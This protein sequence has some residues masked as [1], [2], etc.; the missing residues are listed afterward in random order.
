[1]LMCLYTVSIISVRVCTR[2]RVYRVFIITA[3]AVTATRRVSG[4]YRCVLRARVRVFRIVLVGH[5]DPRGRH[6]HS[7][8]RR[9]GSS[10]R[11]TRTLD[12]TVT[13]NT[14]C[15]RQTFSSFIRLVFFPPPPLIIFSF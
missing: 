10:F 13:S 8:R 15:V 11:P 7:S 12:D 5:D 14:T 6:V 3:A 1:M 9:H 4:V 2:E